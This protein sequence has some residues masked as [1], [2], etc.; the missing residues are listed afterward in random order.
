MKKVIPWIVLVVVAGI[1]AAAY[2]FFRNGS[3]REM[4]TI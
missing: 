3:E 2:E 4:C 1:A